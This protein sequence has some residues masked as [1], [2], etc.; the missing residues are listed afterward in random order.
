MLLDSLCLIVSLIMSSD[1]FKGESLIWSFLP[2]LFIESNVIFWTLFCRI[3]E[4]L[5]FGTWTFNEEELS[6]LAFVIIESVFLWG[7]IFILKRVFCSF[8]SLLLLIFVSW[9]I[10]LDS[11]FI[12]ISLLLSEIFCILNILLFTVFLLKVITCVFS[13]LFFISWLSEVVSLIGISGIF[14]RFI[15]LILP[16]LLFSEL[17]DLDDSFLPLLFEFLFFNDL[18]NK[19]LFSDFLVKLPFFSFWFCVWVF[20]ALKGFMKLLLNLWFPKLFWL[21]LGWLKLFLV[22]L[23][24]FDLVTWDLIFFWLLSWFV[25]GFLILLLATFLF[26]TLA[27]ILLLI[28]FLFAILA[29]LVLWPWELF[30]IFA[31]FEI[32]FLFVTFTWMLS[33]L[34]LSFSQ[35][36]LLLKCLFNKSA[37]FLTNSLYLKYFWV[38]T[39][40]ISLF[41]SIEWFNI[42]PSNFLIII[43]G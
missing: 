10:T 9:F 40:K 42:F 26:W 8:G 38:Y 16:V 14:G 39:W 28:F 20:A 5:L 33:F 24:L 6:R 30:L 13:L 35:N 43:S 11:S 29:L 21:A 34:Y 7:I 19:V 4:E 2:G 41:N 32:L 27:L 25:W 3:I 23:I 12:S 36:I 18:L 31:L 17:A 1:F 37:I 22:L 15:N